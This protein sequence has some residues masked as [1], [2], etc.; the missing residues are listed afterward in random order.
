MYF[1]G[2]LGIASSVIGIFG[3]FLLIGGFVKVRFS[4]T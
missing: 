2:I 1:G 4:I 3:L